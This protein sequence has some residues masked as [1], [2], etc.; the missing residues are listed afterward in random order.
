MDVDPLPP[1][2]INICE[3]FMFNGSMCNDSSYFKIISPPVSRWKL[4]HLLL[5]VSGR[6]SPSWCVVVYLG[7]FWIGV[8]L[9]LKDPAL[10]APRGRT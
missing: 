2:G 8:H 5:A 4:D 6:N 7:S 10:A 1:P 9:P 3:N